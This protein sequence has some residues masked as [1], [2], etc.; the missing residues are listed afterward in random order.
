MRKLR[1]ALAVVLLQSCAVA[2][3][4]NHVTARTNGEG[5]SLL[6]AGSTIGAGGTGWLP[7]LKYSIGLAEKFDLGFQYE[8]IQYGV[9]GKYAFLN[10]AEGFS[11]AALAG[12]GLGLEGFY[13]FGGPVVS[14]KRGWFEPYFITRFNYVRFPESKFSIATIG[15][16]RVDPGTYRYFQHT[17]G[18]MVWP[19]DWFG[20]GLEASIFGTVSSPFILRDADRAILSGNFSF[21]F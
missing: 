8:V 19:G 5:E 15:E 11:L 16:F 12:T 7:S 2:P 20:L 14:W 9:W 6:T 1:L 18:F 10:Q 17:L 3:V 21:R 4:S 13:F